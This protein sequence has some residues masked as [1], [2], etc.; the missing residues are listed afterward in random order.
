MTEQIV[1]LGS[2]VIGLSLA[3]QLAEDESID[4]K[5]FVLS[6]SKP[7]NSTSSVAAAFWYPY[8]VN[9]FYSSKWATDSLDHFRQ[10]EADPSTGVQS[11][12]GFE[13]FADFSDLETATAQPSEDPGSGDL[14]WRDLPGINYTELGQ[15]NWKEHGSPIS[16]NNAG[17]AFRLPT[18]DVNQSPKAIA[19]R[20]AERKNKGKHLQDFHLARAVSFRIPVI[21]MDKYL[22]YLRGRC[23]NSGVI[24]L[25]EHS[26]LARK[27]CAIGMLDRELRDAVPEI[28]RVSL[29]CNCAGADGAVYSSNQRETTLL[30]PIPGDVIHVRLNEPG[31]QLPL[32]FMHGTKSGK[33]TRQFFGTPL[34]VVPRVAT[35]DEYVLGG[36]LVD[37]SS[38]SGWRKSA[39]DRYWERDENVDKIVTDLVL[40]R[41]STLI[42]AFAS[43]TPIARLRGYR[44]VRRHDADVAKTGAGYRDDRGNGLSGV[45]VES[46][47]QSYNNQNF[48][49]VHCYGHGGGGVTLSWGS[50]MYACEL[51]RNVLNR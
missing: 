24:F 35:T 7:Q 10:L 15:Y 12:K 28:N 48:N 14:W 32:V 9:G 21:Q 22:E 43:A 33:G 27:R 34:Y 50:A 26:G 38:Y 46:E 20:Y 30:R 13:Y 47:T 25:G 29:W 51:V 23:E 18:F 45:R 37:P 17:Q 2:G 19:S 1:V 16:R 49:V 42:A 8:A 40:D 5:V 11:R 4:R 44:P 31:I 3:A 39:Y 41:V 6:A 36:T